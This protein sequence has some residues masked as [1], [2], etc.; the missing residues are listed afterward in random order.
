MLGLNLRTQFREKIALSRLKTIYAELR[1]FTMIPEKEFC[2]N[3][4]LAEKVK[5]VRGCVVE[6]GVWRG[7]MIA[8]LCRILGPDREY[9]LLDSFQGLPPAQQIDGPAAIKYQEDKDSP[10]Y[11]DNCAA[12]SEFATRAMKMVGANHFRLIPGFFDATLP[13]FDPGVPIALLRLD[14]DW[15]ESTIACLKN[16]FHRVAPDGIIII[17]DYYAWDGCSRA[18]HDFLSSKKAT[19]RIR[20]FNQ[21]VCFIIKRVD[22]ATS[23]QGEK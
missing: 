21:S 3:L 15:Y 22:V 6:C 14:A 20:S 8:G 9:F 11:Y 7:G 18:V 13:T 12:P 4:M 23:E 10:T 19:E 16:L 1:E 2:E 17:D 5:S